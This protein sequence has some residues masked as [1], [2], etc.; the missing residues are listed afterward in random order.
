MI[1]V[2]SG[3]DNTIT[4]DKLTSASAAGVGVFDVLMR[5]V[6][7]QL[8]A[9]YQANRIKGSEY[10]TV[11]LGS[12]QA[13]LQTSLDFLLQKQ[14]ASLEAQLLEQ[15]ILLAQTEVLKSE[16]QRQALE[17]SLP[18]ITAEIDQLTAQTAVV[19]QQKLNLVAE[20]LNIEKQ[21][22]HLDA[23]AALSTQ[24]KLNLIAEALNIPTQGLVLVAQERKLKAE[25]D[26]LLLQN[27][28]T[29]SETILL[30]QKYATERSQ[31]EG[32]GVDVDSII[33]RQKALYL[34]QSDGFKRDAEHKAAQ[35][36][37]GTWNIRRTTDGTTTY[38]DYDNH[39]NDLSIGAVVAKLC[40]GIGVTLPTAPGI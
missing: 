23:Q 11:Y 18:K 22:L 32:S 39:L 19:T 34:A 20:A 12:L 14:K 28:R 6:K 1:T 10:A 2:A 9:E 3:S 13:V 38:A 16:L 31:I 36:L 35:L 17:A 15:Q 7:A 8:D 25:Y 40:D 24:Q 21:G 4:L 29:I 37:L 27:E 26:N 33:G 5:S 30:T